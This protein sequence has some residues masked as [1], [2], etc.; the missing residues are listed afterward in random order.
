M[1][2]LMS[3]IAFALLDELF[4]GGFLFVGVVFYPRSMYE[5]AQATQRMVAPMLVSVL[6]GSS[7]M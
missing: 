4:G 6:Q 1:L 2:V 5:T 3:A 7:M